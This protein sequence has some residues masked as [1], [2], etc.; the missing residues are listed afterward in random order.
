M[1]VLNEFA[2][3]LNTK[4]IKLKPEGNPFFY[5]LN[6]ASGH[7][8]MSE[9]VTDQTVDKFVSFSKREIE[10]QMGM[11]ESD[12]ANPD[13]AK[14]DIT[15]LDKFNQF[16]HF[17]DE[18][19]KNLEKL[20][21]KKVDSISIP[22]HFVALFF[23]QHILA[24]N[25]EEP[26]S[27]YIT[28][29]DILTSVPI[30]KNNILILL[31][32]KVSGV[33]PLHP[34]S[35]AFEKPKFSEKLLEVLNVYKEDIEAKHSLGKKPVIDTLSNL[36]DK[37]SN[38]QNG[39]NNQ[40]SGSNITSHGPYIFNERRRKIASRRNSRPKSKPNSRS[41]SIEVPPNHVEIVHNLGTNENPIVVNEKN[42]TYYY[43]R[44]NH[45]PNRNLMSNRM[46]RIKSRIRSKSRP[47]SRPK[48]K[49]KRVENL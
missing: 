36:I 24:I 33:V 22:L 20:K 43:N 44:P 15:T 28:T 1:S 42:I 45:G 34:T 5:P 17:N 29:P 4:I 37:M 47:K 27:F 9:K 7:Y 46:S 49:S 13:K 30:T 38:P 11:A 25:P 39:L 16:K 3:L 26:H 6:Y 31:N 8:V 14:T 32:T 18:F 19:K 41:K 2:R 23:K 21:M 40:R 35:I 10:R 48:S 12:L